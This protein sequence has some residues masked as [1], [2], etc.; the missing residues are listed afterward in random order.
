MRAKSHGVLLLGAIFLMLAAAIG[1]AGTFY[2]ESQKNIITQNRHAELFAV[3]EL[4]VNQISLWRKERLE[5][6]YVIGNNPLFSRGVQEWLQSP[7]ESMLGQDILRWMKTLKEHNDYEDVLLADADGKVRL[8]TNGQ[9]SIDSHLLGLLPRVIHDRKPF[10][11]ELYRQESRKGIRLCLLA[12]ILD[13]KNNA[14][15]STIGILLLVIDPYRFLYPLIQSWPTPAATSETLLVLRDG[16]EVVFLNELKYRKDS[17]LRLRYPVAD[18]HLPAARAVQWE[19]GVVEGVDYRGVPVL[20]S[21]RAVSG[22]RWFLVAKVDME[23]VYEPLRERAKIIGLTIV[24]LIGAAAVSLALF[25]SREQQESL[26]KAR[27]ELELRVNE[28]TKELALANEALKLDEY[29]LQALVEL[30]QMHNTSIEKIMD[31]ALDQQVKLTGSEVGTLGFM[32]EDETVFTRYA[33]SHGVSERCRVGKVS[34]HQSIEK[35]GIWADC[36]RKREPVIVNRYS[37][38]GRSGHPEGHIPLTR[39]MSIPVFDGNKIVAVA[40]VANKP[41]DYDTSD[42]RQLTLLMDGMW[43]LIQRQ[44]AEKALRDAESLTAMGRAL[45]SVAHDM[46]TPLIAIG[47]FAQMVHRHLEEGSQDQAKLGI[48]IKETRRLEAMVKDMLDFS[49]PLELDRHHEDVNE[50]VEECIALL[51]DPARER[52]VEIRTSLAPGLPPVSFDA[53]RMKQVIINLVMNAVQASPVG[54]AVLIGTRCNHSKYMIDVTDS[55]CGIPQ[56][57]REEIFRPFVSNKKDGTGLGLAIVKKIIEAHDGEV[58]ILDNPQPEGVTFR[59]SLPL[60]D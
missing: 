6:A 7:S 44:K 52:K 3:A 17:A 41:H 39:F 13:F 37:G 56:E 9:G 24:I 50:I 40:L 34:G 36:V 47:G 5:E 54:A 14:D 15:G 2:Y 33:W 53:M 22:S 8:S 29:R 19:E 46:K 16:D 42:V 49:R 32:N 25:M 43:K 18:S 58:Q 35:S 30:S 59:V 60:A 55:G 38:S 4:K 11:S 21:T 57:K 48:V 27:D 31:F 51:R 10:L 1:G 26:R 20:A 45:S 23:E 12:P 28:K